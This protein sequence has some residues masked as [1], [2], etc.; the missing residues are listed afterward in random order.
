MPILLTVIAAFISAAA[1][2]KA[3]LKEVDTPQ[4]IQS[5]LRQKAFSIRCSPL[6]IPTG[7]DMIPALSGWGNY[8]WKITTAS[9]S[10]QFYFDQGINMYYAFHI[11]ESRA[12]FQKAIY[13]D[14]T[15]AMAWWGKALAFGPNI[16]DFG[17]Q[18]PSEAY[19]SAVKAKQLSSN[20]LQLEKDLIDAI[21]VRYSRDTATDQSKLNVF[22][23]DEM[24][25]VYKAHSSN[26]DVNALYADA[27]MLLHPWDLYDH[28]YQPKKWTPEL[29]QVIK[30]A[31]TLNAKHPGANHYFIHA[32]EASSRPADAL[33]SAELL[34]E[35]MPSVS[36][37]TH[38]P[39]HIFI[40]TGYYNKGI[41]VNDKAV[42][43]YAKYSAS[44]AP[45]TENIALYS[46]HNLHM[47]LNC[48]QM[49][50][51]YK[52][53]MDGSKELSKQI[54]AFYLTIPG[55]LG[56]LVQYLDQSKLFTDVRF[57]KWDEILTTSIVDS[58]P[59]TGLL[60]QF[61]RGVAFARKNKLSEARAS[62]I[63]LQ[64]KMKNET[65]KEPLVPFN[66]AYSSAVI[67]EQLLMGII[68]EEQHD[69]T[70][71]ITHFQLAVDAE[72]KLI[73]NEPR[74]WLLPSRQYLGNV[75]LK[76]KKYTM[77]EEVFKKDLSIN[78]N[79]GWS[80]TGLKTVY[81]STRNAAALASTNARLKN[82]W[83]IKDTEIKQA[84]F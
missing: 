84:V 10:A 34:S 64:L 58:L 52:E 25:K 27:L 56:N 13:F 4:T 54:P 71:A 18:R 2:K 60:Q 31:L 19:S 43:G 53:A 9:D 45:T 74:D 16:N 24:A 12:S 82:A 8:S 5:I 57:G 81:T 3:Q 23:R 83:L 62:L 7:E 37:I 50:G 61:A 51:N 66:S 6:Y 28:N 65:L 69:Y 67:A 26:V 68:A 76:A 15:C 48:A 72:D 63:A 75:L 38:M 21:A 59:Y 55:A 39:S 36:H 78:P 41:Q 42:E 32:V 11:I 44:F 73:Y 40:R 47:K 70:T 22:Y 1:F 49:A 17:Y 20:C 30:Q 29:V 77:A 14:S 46:L 33:R 79:N 80:L 35:S